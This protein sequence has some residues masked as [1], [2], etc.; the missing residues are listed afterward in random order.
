[1]SIIVDKKERTRFL[2]FALVGTIGAIIDF[3]I[4]NLVVSFFSIKAVF[5][6]IISFIAA[7]ISNF[8]WN[9]FWTYPDSRN[10]AFTSQLTQF[11]VVSIVGLLIR[12][13]SFIPLE[14][15]ILD[16]TT[17]TFNTVTIIS[18]KTI[19]HNITLAILIIVVMFWNFFANRYWTYNDVK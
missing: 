8:L 9:R 17:K 19:G 6:S 13:I 1:M 14:T 3:G 18:P 12:A 11:V 15:I 2:K 4:F 7:V 10:K 5:A 16:I